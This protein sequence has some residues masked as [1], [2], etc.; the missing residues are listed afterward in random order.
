MSVNY[1]LIKNHSKS[2]EKAEY[3][4]VTVENQMVG[5]ER[6]GRNIQEATTL[7]RADVIGTIAALKDEIADQLMSGNGVHLPGIGYFSLAVKGNVYEDPRTHRHRLRNAEVRT[8]K[9][10]PDIEM[11]DTLQHTK[12]ENVT[13]RHG[14]SSVPTAELTDKALDDLFSAKPF[15]TVAD[16][17]DYLN[18]SSAN[19]YRIAARLEAEG[20]LRDVG[21]R[22]RKAYV[23]GESQ[24]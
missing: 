12:F 5:L 19:A 14:T 22:Y 1:K 18:L 16:L 11:L 8:V 21:S 24:G 9:F 3:R 4:A 23:R 10:R 6:I 15:I 13:Y 2:A 7:T 17:R 20:K